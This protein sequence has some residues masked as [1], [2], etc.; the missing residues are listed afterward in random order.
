MVFEGIEFTQIK[1]SDSYYVSRCG[2]VLST[3]HKWPS[4]RIPRL[5][6]L[7]KNRHGYLYVQLNDK[8]IGVRKNKCV[9]RLVAETFLPGENECVNHI[10]GDQLDNRLE[11]LEWCTNQENLKH[12][13]QVLGRNVGD[14]HWNTKVRSSELS[15]IK[16]LMSSGHSI[17][18]IGKIYGVARNTIT[19]CL[20]QGE[21]A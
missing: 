11:N 4:C 16:E 1:D 8:R 7:S 17:R 14:E 18:S 9:H 13:F 21:V 6:K 10:N 3:A 15:R 12:H 19:R 5:M 20:K 2:K